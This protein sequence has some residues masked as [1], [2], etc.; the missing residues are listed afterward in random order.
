MID[1]YLWVLHALGTPLDNML[2]IITKN[3]ANVI[4]PGTDLRCIPRL[5]GRGSVEI[6]AGNSVPFDPATFRN[7]SALN[8]HVL[9]RSPG[10]LLNRPVLVQPCAWI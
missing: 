1:L 4:E 6:E 3:L 8:Q 10:H 5:D 9:P 2:C 7:Q